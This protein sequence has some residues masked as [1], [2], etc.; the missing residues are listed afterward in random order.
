M[1][2]LTALDWSIVKESLRLY[3]SST[4]LLVSSASY[5][6]KI[7]YASCKYINFA[8]GTLQ[9]FLSLCLLCS[10][11]ASPLKYL[12]LHNTLKQ[13]IPQWKSVSCQSVFQLLEA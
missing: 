1:I 2:I 10:T 9:Q 5:F 7:S 6:V 13:L 11:I 12:Q 3:T 8:T 4:S